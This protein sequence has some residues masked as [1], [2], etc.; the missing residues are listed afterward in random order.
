MTNMIYTLLNIV[1]KFFYLAIFIESREK[2]KLE[3]FLERRQAFIAHT[4]NTPRAGPVI[5]KI[6]IIAIKLVKMRS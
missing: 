2:N 3:N 1:V 4:R 5:C 6:K